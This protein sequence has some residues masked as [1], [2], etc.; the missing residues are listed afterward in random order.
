MTQVSN[1]FKSNIACIG[2]EG[3][4]IFTM[5]QHILSLF[6]SKNVTKFARPQT[7]KV[8]CTSAIRMEKLY[9]REAERRLFFTYQQAKIIIYICLDR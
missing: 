3:A 5:L 2:G 8:T 6:I 1:D 9:W 4:K 7:F